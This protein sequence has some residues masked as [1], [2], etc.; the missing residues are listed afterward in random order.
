ME[1]IP[2]MAAFRM[3]A[4]AASFFGSLLA[5]K[6]QSLTRTAERE[7]QTVTMADGGRIEISWAEIERP[8]PLPRRYSLRSVPHL[9]G[10]QATPGAR[11]GSDRFGNMPA[12]RRNPSRGV[13]QP[14]EPRP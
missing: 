1:K 12:N 13:P 9:G 10:I 5:Q 14:T 3:E 7:H 4:Q 2:K 6:D 8:V 11:H